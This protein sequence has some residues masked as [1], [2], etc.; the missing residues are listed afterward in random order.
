MQAY[1]NPMLLATES[2]PTDLM[3]CMEI[4]SFYSKPLKRLFD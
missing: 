3:M 4:P 2:T 1:I